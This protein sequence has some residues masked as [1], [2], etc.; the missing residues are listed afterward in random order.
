MQTSLEYGPSHASEQ[1][2]LP[3]HPAPEQL[4]GEAA[5][6]R[7]DLFALGCVLYRALTG[8]EALPEFFERGWSAP[9]DPARLV[10]ETPR[11][12]AKV[13]LACLARSP[14]SRPQSA[15][16]V[17]EQLRAA[18]T[19]Q[20]TADGPKRARP[21]VST[22]VGAGAAALLLA[23]LGAWQ[24][25]PS[26]SGA[27]AAR[28]IATGEESGIVRD[29]GALFAAGFRSSR[30]L[31][32]GI[33]ESYRENGFPPLRNAVRD[34]EALEAALAGLPADR[35]ETTVLT[36]EEATFDGIRAALAELEEAL[37]PEDRALIYFAGHGVP[38][39]RSGSSGF[40]IPADGE[41]LEKDRSRTRW[42]HFD[43]FDRF[44]KD[45]SAKHVLLAM[46]CCYGGR[47]AAARSASVSDYQERFLTRPARVVLAAGRADE[48]VSDGIASGH[49]PFAQVFLDS[50]THTGK[51]ITSSMLHAEMLRTFTERGLPQTPVLAFPEDVPPGEFVFLLE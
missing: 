43:A 37:E 26:T 38:H 20:R 44:L 48:Q 31:L 36:E 18:G 9:Q 7:S 41:S 11:E 23:G 8:R 14:I 33:G 45:A 35:W 42:L 3:A 22:A 40:L 19:G 5:S 25:W 1:A 49:S 27:G 6:A 46:D 34:V 12:L 10:P 51:A 50:L 13:V 29:P 2:A 16:E 28:G 24:L 32:I 21:R 4:G 39:E 15:A 47:L 30:A 17:R